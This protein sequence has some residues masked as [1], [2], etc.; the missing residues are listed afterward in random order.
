M[1]GFNTLDHWDEYETAVTQLGEW[2]AAGK[3]AAR[4]DVL[5]GLDR[6]PEALVRL[7]SGEHL[8]KLVVQV[9]PEA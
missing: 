1:E 4:V 2:L 5:D 9:T 8:G 6:A 3:I 7:F